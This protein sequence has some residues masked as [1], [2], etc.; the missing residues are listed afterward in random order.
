[1]TGLF[2]VSR[3]FH[4]TRCCHP[5]PPCSPARSAGRGLLSQFIHG[6]PAALCE[7][8]CR[9]AGQ[10]GRQLCLSQL[11]SVIRLA[12]SSPLIVRTSHC[13][14]TLLRAL[15]LVWFRFFFLKKPTPLWCLSHAFRWALSSGGIINPLTSATLAIFDLIES[16]QRP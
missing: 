12:K 13:L 2:L 3:A 14:E 9:L 5:R 8:N 4:F 15:E 1:M 10:V 11:F 7:L 6:A 16:S